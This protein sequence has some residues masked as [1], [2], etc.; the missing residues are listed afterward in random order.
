MEEIFKLEI[1][2]FD[3]N[4]PT[5]NDMSLSHNIQPYLQYTY[6]QTDL[7]HF[8]EQLQKLLQ[9]TVKNYTLQ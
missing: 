5:K 7:L 2:S 9:I 4:L 1:M 3:E 6:M 8:Q